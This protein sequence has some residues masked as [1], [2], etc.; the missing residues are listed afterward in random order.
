MYRELEPEESDP[1]DD[2]GLTEHSYF[3][4]VEALSEQGYHDIE[5]VKADG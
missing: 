4:E 2:T 1:N 3:G 5:I